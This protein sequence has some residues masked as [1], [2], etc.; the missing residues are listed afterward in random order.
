LNYLEGP[1][2]GI[3]TSCDETSVAVLDGRQVMVNV[4]SSQAELH[5]K[6][7]GVVPEAAARKHAE[8]LLP[9]LD[10][11]LEGAG[12]GLTDLAGIAVTN[13]P[14]L[15]GALS[16]GVSAAKSLAYSLRVP[17]IGVHHLEGHLLSPLMTADVEFPHLCLLVSGGHTE[18]IL[19][20]EPGRYSNIGGTID[21]AAGEAFDKAARALGLGYP[22]GPAIQRAAEGGDAAKYPLP[23]G[24]REPTTNFSF[25]GLKTAVLYLATAEGSG[26]DVASAAASFEE[27]ITGVLADRT[28]RAC[29][30]HGCRTV[31]LVGGV[32]ANRRLRT[33][34]HQLAEE[35]RITFVTPPFELCTDNAAMIAHVGS[36]RLAR[37]ERDGMD[38]DTLAVAQLPGVIGEQP[39]ARA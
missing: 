7:G 18:I 10:V 6:W 16:V 15:V 20:A 30:E 35:A 22:G 21:D 3:E 4:V 24:L 9:T 37:G 29:R 27:T 12:V 26:L 23:R 38:L 25:A 1:V 33:K 5:K 13:R 14:G 39:A 19:V 28:L 11:A 34:M 32:A 17:F 36:L 31:T 2:L 8:A